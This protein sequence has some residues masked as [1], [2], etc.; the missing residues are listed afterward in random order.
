MRARP[1]TG[2]RSN[3]RAAVGAAV[4]GFVPP[5]HGKSDR[6]HEVSTRLNS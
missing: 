6:S 3:R 2:S 5:G 4:L 1:S